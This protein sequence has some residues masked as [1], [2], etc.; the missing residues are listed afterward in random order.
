MHIFYQIQIHT[1]LELPEV[2]PGG[3][4]KPPVD[5]A[6]T[7]N[8]E[9]E[10]VN[11][12]NLKSEGVNTVNLTFEDVNTVN[13]QFEDVNTVNLHPEAAGGL[14]RWPAGLPRQPEDP[15]DEA[16]GPVRHPKRPAGLSRRQPLCR[17]HWQ[18]PF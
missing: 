13:L 1:I 12:V 3:F 18:T 15:S 6:N 11:T 16:G 2:D 4:P 5:H 10:D 14:P 9:S 8:L 17:R 7:V